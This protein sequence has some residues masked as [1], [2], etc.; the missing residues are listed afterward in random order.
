MSTKRKLNLKSIQDK[1]QAIKA[2]EAG[3][4]KKGDIAKEFGIPPNT[5][6]TWLKNKVKIVDAYESSSF[7]PAT[8][9]MRTADYPNLE[10]ALDIWFRNCRAS[11][12]SITGPLFK[13]QAHTLATKLGHTEFKCSDGWLS[14]FK[15]RHDYQFRAIS[16]ESHAAPQDA[17]HTW[18]S[19]VLQTLLSDYSPQDIF[20]CDETGLFFKMQPAKSY[21]FRGEDCP[22]ICQHVRNGEAPTP[23]VREICQ[24]TLL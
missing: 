2:V 4:K 20:N 16:G 3:I 23:C 14:R 19:G 9:K 18:K 17:V 11:S 21:T 8:K 10:K 6:S 22:P 13:D 7:G 5:L 12:V 24:A 1:Y 15:T